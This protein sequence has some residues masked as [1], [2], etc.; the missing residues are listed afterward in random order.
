M[1]SILDHTTS[2][3]FNPENGRLDAMRFANF[4]HLGSNDIA[5]ITGRS[6]RYVRKNPDAN[7]FQKPLTKSLRIVNGLRRLTG[8]KQDMVLIWLNSPHPELD[9]AT[10]LELMKSGEIDVVVDL[11]DDMLT[12]APA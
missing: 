11:V 6:A 5:A 2:E 10:P 1:P 7:S 8:G 9:D 3:V 12:G 4:L